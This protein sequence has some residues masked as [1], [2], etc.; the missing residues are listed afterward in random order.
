MGHRVCC[1]PPCWLGQGRGCWRVHNCSSVNSILRA[2][3]QSFSDW[4]FASQLQCYLC[5]SGCISMSLVCKHTNETGCCA[6]LLFR[7]ISV[8][9]H[10]HCLTPLCSQL[11]IS[12]WID[13]S[14]SECRED[15]RTSFK[16]SG[17][18]YRERHYLGCSQAHSNSLFPCAFLT[19]GGTHLLP[20][21]AVAGLVFTPEGCI[22]SQWGWSLEIWSQENRGSWFF[23]VRKG[24]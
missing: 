5:L 12:V 14:R 16:P 24:F 18:T 7:P 17:A 2:Y 3:A 10:F 20:V 4:V 15:K 6:C 21:K 19:Q 11:P 13:A 9:L 1:S 23:A 8:T 22:M